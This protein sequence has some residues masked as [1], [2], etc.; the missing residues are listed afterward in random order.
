KMLASLA[1]QLF[2]RGAVG[3]LTRQPFKAGVQV[4]SR[5]FGGSADI[6]RK[7]SIRECANFVRLAMSRIQSIAR[8]YFPRRHRVAL[9]SFHISRTA[10][11]CSHCNAR[12]QRSLQMRDELFA[13]RPTTGPEGIAEIAAASAAQFDR[14]AS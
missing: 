7:N 8:S 11:H 12:R 4:Q 1:A 2:G 13:P 3:D 14:D 9:S 10:A 5:E 6:I